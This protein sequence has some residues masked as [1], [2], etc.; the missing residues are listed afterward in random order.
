MSTNNPSNSLKD[1]L[2]KASEGVG[3]LFGKLSV[4]EIYM[5]P[6]NNKLNH[7]LIH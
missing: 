1:T 6:S 3:N 4:F 2:S 5:N 7:I